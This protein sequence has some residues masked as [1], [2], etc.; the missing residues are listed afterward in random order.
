MGCAMAGITMRFF[1]NLNDFLPLARRERAF[2]HAVEGRPSVKDTIESLGVP[3]TEVDAILVN[4]MATDFTYLVAEGDNIAVYPVFLALEVTPSIHLQ[5]MPPAPRFVLDVHLGRLAAYLRMLGYDTLYQNECDDDVL[6]RVSATEQRILL[7]R[8][9]G[10][11]KRGIVTYGY[12]VRETQP[13][14]Q[15]EEVLRRFGLLAGGTEP[16][17]RCLRCNGLLEPV[18]KEHVADRVPETV[19]RDYDEFRACQSCDQIYWKGTHYQRMRGLIARLEQGD[20]AG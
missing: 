11:L 14:R 4:G 9:V 8:D 10:L 12:F 20:A 13:E 6:A 1:G 5:P 3:H 18:P 17:Q 16:F 19:Q 7:T 15:L 2:T